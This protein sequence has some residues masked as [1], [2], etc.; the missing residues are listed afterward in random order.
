[1]VVALTGY[2]FPKIFST[3]PW[4][5]VTG[6]VGVLTY[7][8]VGALLVGHPAQRGNGRLLTAAAALSAIVYLP[9]EPAN[10]SWWPTIN[11]L[12]TSAMVPIGWFLLRYPQS[13]LSGLVSRLLVVAAAIWIPLTELAMAQGPAPWPT[14]LGH[15]N[16]ER[17]FGVN[18]DELNQSIVSYADSGRILLCL[19]FV[20]LL[21]RR[22]IRS[23]GAERRG[24]APILVLGIVLG[25]IPIVEPMITGGSIPTPQSHENR[26]V[27]IALVMIALVAAVAVHL[28][29]HP[30]DGQPD[31]ALSTRGIR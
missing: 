15:G 1:M 23:R 20:I 7:A 22:L 25:L 28:R 14:L 30:V 21:I 27:V 24:L 12:H 4:A 2:A 26:F 16:A 13:R 18:A 17:W 29:R 10:G 6:A 5:A 19:V 31:R 3:A 8:V 9:G 11:A